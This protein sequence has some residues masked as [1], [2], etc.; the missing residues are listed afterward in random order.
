MSHS[1]FL[2]N[3]VKSNW[4]VDGEL[5]FLIYVLEVSLEFL[6]EFYFWE[7]ISTQKICLLCCDS[8][9]TSHGTI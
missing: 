3:A 5:F 7:S 9:Q 8:H 2:K 6:L 1:M 4:Y